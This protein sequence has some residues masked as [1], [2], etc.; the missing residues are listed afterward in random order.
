MRDCLAEANPGLGTAGPDVQH[1]LECRRIIQRREPDG[2][3]FRRHLP[4]REQRRS[5]HSGQKLR[6]TTFPLPART[7]NVC[8]VPLILRSEAVQAV[9]VE[10]CDRC[11]RA[12]VTDRSARAAAGEGNADGIQFGLC[13]AQPTILQHTSARRRSR[14]VLPGFPQDPGCRRLFRQNDAQ[15]ECRRNASSIE[16]KRKAPVEQCP[17]DEHQVYANIHRVAAI[18]VR[19]RHHQMLRR[20]PRCEGPLTRDVEFPDAPEQQQQTEN[21][22][23]NSRDARMERRSNSAGN[24]Q[25]QGQRYHAGDS[26]EGDDGTKQHGTVDAS[27]PMFD[28]DRKCGKHC[29]VTSLGPNHLPW[30]SRVQSPA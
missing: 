1:R 17:P 12:Q 15:V 4:A 30:K 25:R 24:R 8:S 22:G 20:P 29:T 16:Q 21:Q 10:H 13:A 19:A 27:L 14:I 28:R 26:K 3:D 2:Q 6:V 5:A 9:A 18:V 7:A 23:G 11:G